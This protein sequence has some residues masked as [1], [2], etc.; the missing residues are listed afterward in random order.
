MSLGIQ[1]L[2]SL[3][4]EA[5]L[6]STD[7]EWSKAFVYWFDALMPREVRLAGLGDASL[8]HFDTEG[9]P[10]MPAGEGFIDR[11]EMTAISFL[12]EFQE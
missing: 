2:V 10:H 1:R 12:L 5:G 11:A 6:T 9:T 7:R 8:E 3:A 4:N